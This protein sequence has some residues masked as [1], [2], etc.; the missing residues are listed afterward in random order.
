MHIVSSTSVSI[1]NVFQRNDAASYFFSSSPKESSEL[2]K[3][4]TLVLNVASYGVYEVIIAEN[5]AVSE[6]VTILNAQTRS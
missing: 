5:T 3:I 6:L 1:T 2:I 4:N